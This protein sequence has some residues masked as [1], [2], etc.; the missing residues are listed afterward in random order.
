VSVHFFVFNLHMC[1][2][3][4]DFFTILPIFCGVFCYNPIYS[5]YILHIKDSFIY[6]RYIVGVINTEKVNAFERILWQKF[7]KYLIQKI[8]NV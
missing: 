8:F 6:S 5:I 2:R 3:C 4:L 1:S 7:L